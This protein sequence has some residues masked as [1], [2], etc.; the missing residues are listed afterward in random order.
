MTAQVLNPEGHN[1]RK[2]NDEHNGD[3]VSS[4]RKPKHGLT[5]P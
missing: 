5:V 4:R 3:T 1:P 2:V